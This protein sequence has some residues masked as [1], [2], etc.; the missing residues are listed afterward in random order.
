MAL[1]IVIKDNPY[2]VKSTYLSLD[3]DGFQKVIMKQNDR[4]GYSIG[5]RVGVVVP[6]NEALKAAVAELRPDGR[7]DQKVLRKL[8]GM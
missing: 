6:P 1:Y 2:F 7:V 8:L 3:D 4:G 5:E